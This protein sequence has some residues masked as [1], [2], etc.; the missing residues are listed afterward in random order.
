MNPT[1]AWTSPDSLVR[2][3]QLLRITVCIS[4]LAFLVM[5]TIVMGSK[6]GTSFD[7]AVAST[8]YETLDGSSVLAAVGRILDI[9]G[10]NLVAILLVL[11]VTALLIAKRHRYL[12]GYLFASA[13]GGVLLSSVVKSFVDRPRPSTVGTIISESTS[14]FPSG[15]STSGITTFVALAVVCLVTMRPR[16]RWWAAIPL[17]LLG[18]AIGVSRVALGVHWPTDVLGGWALGSAWTSAVALVV[19]LVVAR[20]QQRLRGA[21]VSA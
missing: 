16:V 7:V 12:A 15:H 14:S 11:G 1:D 3:R 5:T 6:A 8:L 2:E 21:P 10:G 18:L 13:L 9:V 20:Q 19:V 4:V 17:S